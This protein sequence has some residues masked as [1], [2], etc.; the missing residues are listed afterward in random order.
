L[1]VTNDQLSLTTTDWNHGVDRLEAGGHR[2]MNRFTGNNAWG[3]DLHLAEGAGVDRT[4]AVNWLANGVH[5]AANQ[6]VANRYLGNTAG[7]LDRIAFFDLGKFTKN[8]GTDVIFLKVENHTGYAAGKFQQLT[9]HGASQ[10]MDTGNTVSDGDNGT[11]LRYL[12]LFA[13]LVNLFL[14]DFANFFGSEFHRSVYPF[15][16]IS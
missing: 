15:C 14:D 9:G 10:A 11:G 16:S 1:T 2:L 12:Y 4:F 13:I 6:G 7:T 8:S 3:L 5:Y